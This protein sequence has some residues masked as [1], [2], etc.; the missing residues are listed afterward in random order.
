MIEDEARQGAEAHFG[1]AIF[2]STNSAKRSNDIKPGDNA[3]VDVRQNEDETQTPIGYH[4]AQI[5]SFAVMPRDPYV[6]TTCHLDGIRLWNIDNGLLAAFWKSNTRFTCAL[7]LGDRTVA[8]GTDRGSIEVWDP[9]IG[10]II[11]SLMVGEKAVLGLGIIDSDESILG[12]LTQTGI[13]AIHLRDGK[14]LW[15][16]TFEAEECDSLAVAWKARK[17]LVKMKSRKIF[18]IDTATGTTEKEITCEPYEEIDRTTWGSSTCSVISFGGLVFAFPNGV[19]VLTAQEVRQFS[20]IKRWD[21][22]FSKDYFYRVDGILRIW[23]MQSGNCIREIVGV[24]RPYNIAISPDGQSIFMYAMHKDSMFVTSNDN[25][26]HYCRN[27]VVIKIID[28]ENGKTVWEEPDRM[29][30]SCYHKPPVF[31]PNGDHIVS[32]GFAAVAINARNGQVL[33]EFGRPSQV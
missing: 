13:S 30:Q 11:I 8:F 3:Q 17:L 2:C 27:S 16:K 4:P 15:V 22:L 25:P 20:H 31:G 19:H 6:V 18:V 26:A 14:C 7:P 12:V 23:D 1:K 29:N 33:R 9:I 24:G 28:V 5:D 21:G 10:S 32:Q